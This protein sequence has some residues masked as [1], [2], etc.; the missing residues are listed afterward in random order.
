MRVLPGP[1]AAPK[2]CYRYQLKMIASTFSQSP[3]KALESVS[4]NNA[5]V[6]RTA[7][8]LFKEVDGEAR[9]TDRQD[10]GGETGRVFC[11]RRASC[12]LTFGD[13]ENE[14]QFCPKALCN[15]E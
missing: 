10:S 5:F 8:F 15:V 3:C 12:R 6:E 1:R 9:D 2:S 11:C 7:D 4:V 14:A 13:T